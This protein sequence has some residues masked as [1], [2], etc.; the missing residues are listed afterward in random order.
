MTDASKFPKSADEC[1]HTSIV[2]C[3]KGDYVVTEKDTSY[4][5]LNYSTGMENPLAR[6]TTN[7]LRPLNIVVAV[8]RFVWMAA[9]NNR[10]QD[11]AY[12]EPKV[13]G[14]TDNGLSVPGS[15]YGNRLFEPRPGVNQIAGVVARLKQNPGTRRA[16]AVVWAPEDAVRESKDIPCTFGVFFHIR[17]GELNMSTAMR[18]NNAYRILPFNLFEFSMLQE[19][20]AAELSLP[21]GEYTHWAAS[22]H[23]YDNDFEM[24]NTFAIAAEKPG[25]SLVMPPMPL[26]NSLS[27][28]NLLARYEANMRHCCSRSEFDAIVETAKKML[29][30]YW[31]NLF[32][33]LA[34]YS[35]AKRK[36]ALS[37]PIHMTKMFAPL[38]ESAVAK[39]LSL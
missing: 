31:L 32:S 17:G 22:M 1:L 36:Y 10:L 21:I 39:M 14:F 29:N 18:S 35:A 19:L 4:E 33:V 23:L 38:T 9:G 28:V 20:V 3:L 11:I 37:T 6:I 8:A 27:Q 12:Y 5:V 24:P 30:P 16:A 2:D 7:P 15:C 25:K 13:G 34:V 26:G